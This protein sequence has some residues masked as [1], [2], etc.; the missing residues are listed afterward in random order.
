M[1]SSHRSSD[2]PRNR[3]SFK[4]ESDLQNGTPHI[5]GKD[6]TELS[7]KSPSLFEEL[8]LGGEVDQVYGD[9]DS[10]MRRNRARSINHL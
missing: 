5:K 6:S 3:K 2:R 8:S 9:D 7:D 1:D 10:R 4:D